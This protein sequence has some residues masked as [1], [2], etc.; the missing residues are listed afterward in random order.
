MLTCALA[1][2]MR[3]GVGVPMLTRDACTVFC[4]ILRRPRA[5]A[6]RSRIAPTMPTS[7]ATIAGTAT[8]FNLV[9]LRGV[10]FLSYCVETESVTV[11]GTFNIASFT[12]TASDKARERAEDRSVDGSLRDGLDMGLDC[13]TAGADPRETGAPKIIKMIAGVTNRLTWCASVLT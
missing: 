11:V 3:T 9:L 1:P 8:K 2:E 7:T 12:K 4:P 5:D 6:I 10:R 13:A